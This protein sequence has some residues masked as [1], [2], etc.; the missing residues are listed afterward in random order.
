MMIPL[1][2]LYNRTRSRNNKTRRRSTAYFVA[3]TSPNQKSI[4]DQVFHYP[5]DG[6]DFSDVTHEEA[7]DFL[8]DNG[9]V[10]YISVDTSFSDIYHHLSD[11]TGGR[12]Y[13]LGTPWD[14]IFADMM[15]D[16]FLFYCLG[17][18]VDGLSGLELYEIELNGLDEFTVIAPRVIDLTDE[19]YEGIDEFYVAWVMRYG[20]LM[21]ST[22]YAM[23]SFILRTSEGEFTYEERINYTPP[24]SVRERIETIPEQVSLTISPNP[25]NSACV[26]TS[27]EGASIEIHELNGKCVGAFEKTPCLWQPDE[28]IGSG[29]YLIRAT[30]GER[31]V[32]E[33]VVYLK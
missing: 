3:S 25:F 23:S 10:L 8:L 28:T 32:S 31:M 4:T 7:L 18:R 2:R 5:G 19:R 16:I 14:T 17:L 20:S 33:K 26:I 1:L 9:F 6:T 13:D 22:E 12:S 24:V 29:V 15:D 27:L 30:V 21:R 11:T